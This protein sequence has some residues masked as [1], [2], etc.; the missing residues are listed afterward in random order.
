MK[1]EFKLYEECNI[2]I[3][4]PFKKGNYKITDPENPKLIKVTKK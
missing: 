3:E 1:I 4:I 2:D